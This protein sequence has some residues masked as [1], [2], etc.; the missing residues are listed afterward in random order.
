MAGTEVSNHALQMQRLIRMRSCSMPLVTH[1]HT[2]PRL[3]MYFSSQLIH[4]WNLRVHKVLQQ[5]ELRTLCRPLPASSDLHRFEIELAFH[6]KA[7]RFYLRVVTTAVGFVHA[8][9]RVLRC[10]PQLVRRHQ[11]SDR[12]TSSDAFPPSLSLR[13]VRSSGSTST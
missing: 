4:V 3:D 6:P 5:T 2:L 1:D 8:L 11:S 7:I 13:P 9:V 12:S 10:G